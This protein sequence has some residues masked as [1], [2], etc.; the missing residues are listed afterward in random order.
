[1]IDNDT[2]GRTTGQQPVKHQVKQPVKHQVESRS[3][4]GQQPVKQPEK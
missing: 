3:I 4:Q 2:A 1:M